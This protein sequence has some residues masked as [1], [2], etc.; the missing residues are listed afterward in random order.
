MT[1]SLFGR[2]IDRS[3]VRSG[4]I[5]AVAAVGLVLI[6]KVSTVVAHH[7][8]AEFT[9][10]SQEIAGE[11]VVVDWSN[12]HPTFVLEVAGDAGTELWDIQGY[13]SLYTLR[14]AGVTG[15]YFRAGDSVRLAGS[16]SSE[17]ENVFLVTH[18]LLPDGREV[19]FQRDA[20][21]MWDGVATIGGEDSYVFSEDDVVD[22]AA[23]N[24]GIFR[25]W[26]R[27]AEG[28]GT[29]VPNVPPLTE[30]AIAA[31]AT[32]DPLEETSENC[33]PKGMPMAM[34][35]PHPFEFVDNGDTITVL[36][37]EFNI[38]RTI[39]I[40]EAGDPGEQPFSHLGYSVGRWEGNTLV[41][42]TSR[43]NW[44]FFNPFAVPL[45]EAVEVVERFTISDDQSRLDWHTTVTDSGTFVGGPAVVRGYW[46]ALGE[47]P[48]PY[49]CRIDE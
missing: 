6:A 34:F 28:Q 15:D 11:L 18:M 22:A 21:P 40:G 32:F 44:P 1:I 41:V 37:H 19:V 16:I 46:L 48:E 13:G 39:H 2:E 45:S 38:E 4:V 14:R 31:M 35:T 33:I 29:Y 26:S 8:R 47:T 43:I 42:E 7:S 49:D 12:P 20:A 9:I 25:L 17:R 27:P 3:C 5:P 24:R 23:E 30:A 36:G 10:E